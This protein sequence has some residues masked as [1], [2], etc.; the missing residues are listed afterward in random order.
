VHVCGWS[1]DELGVTAVVIPARVPRLGAEV[2]LSSKA[3]AAGTTGVAKPG[4]PDSVAHRDDVAVDSGPSGDDLADDLV[5]GSD[6]WA[7][8]RKVAL[9][10][11]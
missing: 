3:V 6:V 2:L 11:V 1:G 9:D 8:H 4:H 7:V 5:A 10:Y